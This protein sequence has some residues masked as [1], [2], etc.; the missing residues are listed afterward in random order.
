MQRTLKTLFLCALLGT[1]VWF[2]WKPLNNFAW[3]V[4]DHFLPCSRPIGYYI[5]SFDPRFGVSKSDFLD[6]VNQA[7]LIW[8]KS[9]DRDLFTFNDHGTLPI[10]LIYDARQQET[11]QRSSLDK[12]ISAVEQQYNDKRAEFDTL[13]SYYASQAS[14]YQ[15]ALAD[16]EQKVESYSQEVNYWNAHGGATPKAYAEL[17]AQKNALQSMQQALEQQKT[18]LDATFS[19]LQALTAQVNA[20]AREAN[21]N[22]NTYNQ[23]QF[24]GKEFDAGLYTQDGAETEISIFQ[25]EDKNKLIRVLAHELGHAL[26]L[27]HNSNPQSIMYELNSSTNEKPTADDVTALKKVC[28]IKS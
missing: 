8:E 5:G 27:P 14:D 19:K 20:L 9:V 28:H 21:G 12:T 24:V 10:N 7:S 11:Q 23:G 16:F 15:A 6:A 4:Y 13:K 25:F 18:A 17:S 22:I 26:G 1:I 2:N 3:Q